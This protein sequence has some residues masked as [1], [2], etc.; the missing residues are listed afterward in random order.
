[1]AAAHVPAGW[2]NVSVCSYFWQLKDKWK[3]GTLSEYVGQRV[4]NAKQDTWSSW[5][6]RTDRQNTIITCTHLLWFLALFSF[7]RALVEVSYSLTTSSPH[8]VGSLSFSGHKCLNMCVVVLPV[9]VSPGAARWSSTQRKAKCQASKDPWSWSW[10]RV[11]VFFPR[12]KIH[13][14]KSHFTLTT[15]TL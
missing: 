13:W 4:E 15:H 11:L 1:M 10:T 5:H 9:G 14:A 2:K 6:T 3:C 7:N 8:L 12:P